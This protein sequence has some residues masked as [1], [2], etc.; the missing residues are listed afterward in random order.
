MGAGIS[1]WVLARSVAQAGQLG[2]VSGTA[3][4]L[5]LARRLQCGDEGGH[6]R[7]AL[8]HF[9]VPEL[10]QR[11]EDK[12][13]IEGGKAADQPFKGKSMVGHNRSQELDELL[14]V[15]A[16]VEV[17]LAKEGH[18]GL[19]GINVLEKIQAPNLPT[20]YGAMLAH[21][22]VVTMGAGVPTATPGIIS[23]YITGKPTSVDLHFPLEEGAAKPKLTFDPACI[24]G[25]NPPTLPRPLF[26]PI[27]AAATLAVMMMKKC[28][29][30]IDGFVIE[31]PTAGGHN[32]PPRGRTK[33]DEKGEPI[34]GKRDLVDYEAIQSHGI[35]FWIGGS[36]G[37]PDR[38][39]DAQ[40]VGAV[41]IQ[42]GTLF[43]FS[44]E[45]GL[46]K[47]L[48]QDT[49]A[50]SL[51][52]TAG[53]FT[54][55]VA[56]PTGFPFKVL[57]MEGTNSDQQQYEDRKRVCDLGYLRHAYRRPD[58]ALGWR[59]ASEPLQAWAKKGGD[60]EATQG[61]KCLC[62][63]LMANIGMP[64]YRSDG[65]TERP[66]ITAGDEVKK[67]HILLTKERPY[68]SATDVLDYLLSADQEV[69]H[70]KSTLTA[71]N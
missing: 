46:E 51:A 28:G 13:F 71:E 3:L 11:I 8:A 36:Y 9:P 57:Q 41:G 15:S 1:N 59:C 30:G 67:I 47:T 34:Y 14:V 52:G 68:Y 53:V 70:S 25:E 55:P 65:T 26:I 5:I 22:D 45:S 24:F 56:S 38:L 17:Y 35:P 20:I 27:I 16:F 37:S 23:D 4:D 40:E 54:D 39:L 21:V 18:D 50:M 66:L 69:P 19:V 12:Y 43:A 31:T 62:N 32:A 64:Q 63:G 49:R 2:V 10:A 60:E 6:M 44:D 42:V 61:R 58:G 29:D 33:I 7:R 48:K